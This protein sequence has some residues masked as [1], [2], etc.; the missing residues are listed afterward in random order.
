MCLTVNVV[1]GQWYAHMGVIMERKRLVMIDRYTDA[2]VVSIA[3]RH[4]VNGIRVTRVTEHRNI[5][6]ASYTRLRMLILGMVSHTDGWVEIWPTPTPDM[7]RGWSYWQYA[8]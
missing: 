4:T 8:A 2:D 7:L 5:T 6:P 3:R 1:H